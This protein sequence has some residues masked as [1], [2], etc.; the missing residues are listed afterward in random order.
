MPFVDTGFSSSEFDPKEKHAV[1]LLISALGSEVGANVECIMPSVILP[2]GAD[3]FV[4]ILYTLR[5]GGT[6]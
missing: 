1:T 2:P 6:V 4:L 5:V 3:N